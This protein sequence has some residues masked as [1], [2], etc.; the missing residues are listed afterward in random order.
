MIK[1]SLF[2]TGF[3]ITVYNVR[4]CQFRQLNNSDYHYTYFK[5][6]PYEIALSLTQKIFNI[7]Q[8]YI[9]KILSDNDFVKTNSQ[10]ILKI[11]CMKGNLY[12]FYTIT[13]QVRE[14]HIP[15]WD[16]VANKTVK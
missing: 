5:Y 10:V 15:A 13:Y 4:N 2:Y 1:A 14:L 6:E 11:I 9:K 16:L 12:N 8:K 7:M 3:P